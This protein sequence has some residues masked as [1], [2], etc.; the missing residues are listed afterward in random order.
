MKRTWLSASLFWMSALS[1]L[2]AVARDDDRREPRERPQLESRGEGRGGFE[3][4]GD[5]QR[6]RRDSRFDGRQAPQAEPRAPSLGG[7]NGP[8]QD[9]RPAGQSRTFGSPTPAA[10]FGRQPDRQGPADH[11]FGGYERGYDQRDRPRGDYPRDR[12]GLPHR[13]D[14]E[15]DGYPRQQRDRHDHR[16]WSDRRDG[17]RNDWR[18]R[19]WRQ[20]WHHGWSGQRYRAVERYYYPRG[21]GHR[22]WRIGLTLPSAFFITRY[23]V[24]YRDYGLAPPPWGCDWLR[25]GGDLLL[26]ERRSGY[27]IDVLYNFFY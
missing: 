5:D 18:H 2:P 23:Y 25:V 9:R 7:F 26:V 17:W 16:D 12:G 27:V 11:R 21:F 15:R 20:H 4:G 6:E 13:G 3:R 1:V 19:D 10:G 22:V 24:D 8:F 14:W